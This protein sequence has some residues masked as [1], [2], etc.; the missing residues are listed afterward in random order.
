MK[1]LALLLNEPNGSKE[2][3][4]YAVLLAKDLNATVQILHIQNPQIYGTHE[5]MGT[6]VA[7]AQEYLQK[8][9]ETAK[10]TVDEYILEI[11]NEIS[12]VPAI[13][14]KSEIG[15]ATGILEDKV[16]NGEIDMLMIQGQPEKAFWTQ[17]ISNMEIIRS[18]Q[19]P[20]WIIAPDTKYQAFNKIIYATD[21]KE[22][23][24]TTLNRVIDLTR[25]FLSEIT[26]L[27]ISE[28]DHFVEEVKA[29]GLDEVLKQ[30]TNFNNIRAKMVINK[31]DRDLIDI[32]NEEAE[33][34]NAN[35]IVVLKENRNFFEAIFKSSFTSKL[36]R[37][38]QLPVLVFHEK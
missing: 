33:R 13:E 4:V 24:V 31:E 5:S 25:P 16:A 10:K 37:N 12:S 38:A 9:S 6:A 20:I 2:V 14:F 19:C 3:I 23:D 15:I 34:T 8:N 29:A 35:L 18:V 17:S 21:Y 22:A 26:A 32:L 36:I 27:H 28:K 1:K 30:K 7:Q 11:R